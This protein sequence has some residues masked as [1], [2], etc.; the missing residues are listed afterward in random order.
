MFIKI[1]RAILVGFSALCGILTLVILS[2]RFFNPK[3][4]VYSN[5]S[6]NIYDE[7]KVIAKSASPLPLQTL[8]GPSGEV[9]PIKSGENKDLNDLNYT[10]VT[11]II[12]KQHVSRTVNWSPINTLHD[13]IHGQ[14]SSAAVEGIYFSVKTTQKNHS[15]RLSILLL[16]WM[17]T[18]LPSQVGSSALAVRDSSNDSLF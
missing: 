6:E 16:T 5:A 13:I 3:L 7:A 14:E 12:P 15:I 11:P 10:P 17:Q 2:S 4:R 1:C 9:E 8:L 18:V